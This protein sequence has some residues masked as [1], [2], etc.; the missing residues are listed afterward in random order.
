MFKEGKI[1]SIAAVTDFVAADVASA[2]R[3]MKNGEYIGKIVLHL[4]KQ[5]QACRKL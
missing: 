1:H 3:H 2:F 4:E 5:S